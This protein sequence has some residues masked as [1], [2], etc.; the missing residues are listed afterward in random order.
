MGHVTHD[1]WHVTCDMWHVTRATWHITHDM[2]HLTHRG[3]WALS[4]NFRSLALMVWD[5]WWF[6]DREEKH[7]S[8]SDLIND[9][10]VCRTAPAIPGLLIILLFCEWRWLA[11]TLGTITSKHRLFSK[12]CL[13]TFK[14][15]VSWKYHK[16]TV[17]QFCSRSCLFRY[18]LLPNT[19]PTFRIVL[20]SHF[21]ISRL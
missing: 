14:V 17:S 11:W 18:L 15:A 1:S 12:F 16:F 10:G 8:V 20:H 7:Q 4:Q 13:F 9:G 19:F 3:W 6:E 2:W 5:L 21:G